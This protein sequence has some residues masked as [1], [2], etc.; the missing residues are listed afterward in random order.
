[1]STVPNFL[2]FTINA[3]LHLT[4]IRKLCYKMSFLNQN[5]AFFTEWHQSC[6]VCLI[7]RQNSRYFRCPVWKMKRWQ[8]QQTYMETETCKLYFRVFWIFLSNFIKIDPYNFELYRF[9]VGTFF[10]TQRIST[11]TALAKLLEVLQLSVFFIHCALNSR[12]SG[13]LSLSMGHGPWLFL[14]SLNWSPR[15]GVGFKTPI[16]TPRWPLD[17]LNEKSEWTTSSVVFF[18]F[19]CCAVS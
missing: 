6:R 10:E 1:M 4:F 9:K 19:H 15:P 7:Q 11:G 2:D 5:C 18:V 12:R 17:I 14:M 3:V 16:Y 13:M 8:K